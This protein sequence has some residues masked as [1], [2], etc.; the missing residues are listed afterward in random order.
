MFDDLEQT[1]DD[2]NKEQRDVCV[3]MC[4]TTD[5][6]W[7]IAISTPMMRRV[8]ARLRDSSEMVL[9][10]SSGNCDRHNHCFSFSSLIP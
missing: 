8:H 10:D 7:V 1:L 5:N 3:R 9:V 4:E 2:Y 6:H